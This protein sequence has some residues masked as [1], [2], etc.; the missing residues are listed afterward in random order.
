MCSFSSGPIMHLKA[1]AECLPVDRD[2]VDLFIYLSIP[3]IPQILLTYLS[4][5]DSHSGS[6][7]Y[8]CG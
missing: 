4:D 3:S 8:F 7:R 5:D 2:D 6:V 1:L